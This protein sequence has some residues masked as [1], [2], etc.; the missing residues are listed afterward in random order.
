MRRHM[1]SPS[2]AIVTSG[3]APVSVH[4]VQA[5]ADPSHALV[6]IAVDYRNAEIPGRAYFADYSDVQKGRFGYTLLFGKLIPGK[7]ALRTQIEITFPQEMFARQ[8]WGTSRELHKVVKQLPHKD[9]TAPLH[10][11]EGTERVQTFR[12]NNVFMGV[13]G[14][15][16][17]LDFY[18]LS[19]KDMHDLR[20]R[21]H[22][23]ADV[24]LEPVIRVVLDT[25]LL[26]E[27]LEQ[28]RPFVEE[29]TQSAPVP[30]NPEVSH[31]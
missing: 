21:Q 18:Y 27:F 20:T 12:S 15:D 26:D 28:C 16:S 3:K 13:W 8:L 11:V 19:P 23:R 30:R 10:S 14:E 25:G 6:E 29:R 9:T 17:V 22:A 5:G 1:P 24:S 4:F 7:A 2:Q 31:A